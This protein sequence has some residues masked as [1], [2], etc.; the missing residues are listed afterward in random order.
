MQNAFTYLYQNW[1]SFPLLYSGTLVK[2][3]LCDKMRFSRFSVIY[4]LQTVRFFPVWVSLRVLGMKW[5]AHC[6]QRL[7]SSYLKIQ[8][9]QW[10]EDKEGQR[11]KP[12]IYNI[13]KCHPVFNTMILLSA[14]WCPSTPCYTPLT[15]CR[16]PF[17]YLCV[18]FV[19]EHSAKG[20]SSHWSFG[21]VFCNV[22][23]KKRKSKQQR[24]QLYSMH[25]KMSSYSIEMLQRIIALSIPNFCPEC[26][27][28]YF[29]DTY[30]VNLSFY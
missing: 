15:C 21:L 30:F 23:I 1:W 13:Q 25:P 11:Q 12:Q 3:A 28:K 4:R 8:N 19:L 14:R 24:P 27:N 6:I 2:F 26:N 29:P 5:R 20:F 7:Y 18:I 22:I 17:H 9:F 16:E 10:K